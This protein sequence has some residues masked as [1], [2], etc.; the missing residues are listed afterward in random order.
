MQEFIDN[1]LR[2]PKF[3][4]GLILGIFLA[5]LE[6]L[7]PM[8]NNRVTMIALVGIVLGGLAFLF[9]TL[10]AMLGLTPV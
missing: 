3:L 8:L 1:L 4:I 2:Y 6:R 5:S 9:F 7:R 10:R